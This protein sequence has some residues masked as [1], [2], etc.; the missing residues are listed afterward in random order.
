MEA[1]RNKSWAAQKSIRRGETRQ[2]ADLEMEGCSVQVQLWSAA[3]AGAALEPPELS[4]CP[5]GALLCSALLVDDRD[6]TGLDWTG[7]TELD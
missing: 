4:G 2:E 5:G 6:R 1:R 7:D 3:G